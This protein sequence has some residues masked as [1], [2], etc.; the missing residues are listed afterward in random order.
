MAEPMYRRN[1]LRYPGYDYSQAGA[2]FLTIN[3]HQNQC[4]FGAVNGNEVTLSPSGQ[5]VRY[6]WAGLEKRFPGIMIDEFIVMPNHLHGVI[7]LGANPAVPQTGLTPGLLVNSFKN[8]VS[9]AWRKGV[10]EDGWPRYQGKLWHRDYFERII[11]NDAELVAIR[12]YII[13]NPARWSEKR[14]L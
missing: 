6:A 7:F 14:W 3:T 5:R 9:A 2:Y 8:T 12:E 13:G 1:S 11:R 4:L 10:Q